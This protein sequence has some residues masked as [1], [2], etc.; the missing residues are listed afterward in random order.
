MTENKIED[1]NDDRE[2]KG[3]ESMTTANTV[4][5]L[6]TPSKDSGSHE[7]RRFCDDDDGHGMRWQ[8]ARTL[9]CDGLVSEAHIPRVVSGWS[10]SGGS[11]SEG[12]PVLE[13]MSALPKCFLS[14]GKVIP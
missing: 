14:L 9:R 13:N 1:H 10:E 12:H 8:L 11:A 7:P 2:R 4:A 5:S 6:K 3:R